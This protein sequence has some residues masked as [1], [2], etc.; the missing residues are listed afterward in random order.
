MKVEFKSFKVGM[1]SKEG[2]D[3]ALAINVK[4]IDVK[5]TVIHDGSFLLMPVEVN[6]AM[7]E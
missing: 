3:G 7:H 1:C 2:Q 4:E 6:I 5:S